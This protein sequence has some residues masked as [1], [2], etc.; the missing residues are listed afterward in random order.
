MDGTSQW[1]STLLPVGGKHAGNVLGRAWGVRL[2]PFACFSP[3]LFPIFLSVLKLTSIRV[4]E[5]AFQ[6]GKANYHLGLPMARQH[7]TLLTELCDVSLLCEDGPSFLSF[8]NLLFCF[9]QSWGF[10]SRPCTC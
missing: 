4:E 8:L 2:P 5:L 7:G 10:N 6:L 9:W 3:I 1:E